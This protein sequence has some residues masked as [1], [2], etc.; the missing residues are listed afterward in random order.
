MGAGVQIQSRRY[1]LR[2][3]MQG[4]LPLFDDAQLAQLVGTGG[5]HLI[6]RGKGMAQCGPRGADRRAQAVHQTLGIGAR[7]GHADLLPQ[8][9]AHGQL[10]TVPGTWHADA[11]ALGEIGL[12]NGFH[13]RRVGIQVQSPAHPGEHS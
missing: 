1:R 9:R 4:F 11:A 5:Q 12:Q 13:G 6:W 7:C 10:E 8:H 3:G 2:Q